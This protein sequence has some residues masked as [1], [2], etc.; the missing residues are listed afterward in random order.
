MK[1]KKEQEIEVREIVF[2]DNDAQ[3]DARILADGCRDE[4]DFLVPSGIQKTS[5]QELLVEDN[6]TRGFVLSGIRP[7]TEIGWLDALFNYN[8]D[9]DSCVYIEPVDERKAIDELTKKISQYEA[10]QLVEAERGSIKNTTR[11]ANIL[12]ELYQQ[13]ALLEQNREN[14]FK[15][16]VLAQ[17]YQYSLKVLNKESQKLISRMA[18]KKNKLMPLFLRQEEAYRSTRPFGINH[19][20]DYYRNFGTGAASDCFPFYN[21]EYSQ[22]HGIMFA[23]NRETGTPIFIDPF[24][25]TIFNNANI[26][27]FGGSGSGKTYNVSLLIMHFIQQSCYGVVIDADGEFGKVTN[28]TGGEYLTIAPGEYALNP[29]DVDIED[30][31]TEDGEPTGR[32]FINIK[33]KVSSLL[34][35]IAIMSGEPISGDSRS[36]ISESLLELYELFGFTEDPNSLYQESTGEFDEKSGQFITGMSKKQ[37]PIFSDLHKLITEKAAR[38]Q[39]TELMRIANSLSI[40]CRGGLY[41]MFDGQTTQG[42]DIENAPLVVFNVSQLEESVLRPIGM[43]IVFSWLW[44]K[45]IKKHPERKKVVVLEEAWMLIKES[46]AGSE[47]TAEFVE[48]A[49][50]RIRKRNGSL[51]VSSQNVREFEKSAQGQAVLDNTTIKILMRQEPADIN[52]TQRVFQLSEGEKTSLLSAKRGDCLIKMNETSTKGIV[53]AFDFED[54]LI[55]KKYLQNQGA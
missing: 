6:Y 31:V 35:M 38:E 15:V 53:F 28:A 14:M 20:T 51:I 19:I 33:E 22:D 18:G 25:R 13:R 24:D 1:K 2:N 27:I 32:R 7:T 17:M 40:F 8:G 55:S 4:K 54:K 46:L 43:Y 10:S 30:E 29:F 41:D 5:E 3:E 49:A 16:E 34:N 9:M 47:Y 23:I 44:D 52:T 42:V 37:M 21:A 50:R 45:F 36:K 26:A 12:K 11:N 48:K 39:D